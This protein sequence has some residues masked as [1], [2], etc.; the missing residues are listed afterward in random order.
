[1][2]LLLHICCAPCSV[3][4]AQDLL[5]K[6]DI[7]LEGFF[8]NPNI[9]PEEELMKRKSA[10]VSMSEDLKLQVSYDDSCLTDYWRNYLTEEKLARCNVCYSLRL[11][12]AAQFARENGFDAFT[13][14]LLISP[15]QDH[16]LIRELGEQAASK[17]HLQFHYQD[18]RPLYRRGREIARGKNWYMQKFCGCFY[19]YTESTH[20]KKPIYFI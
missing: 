9:H 14:S 7:K 4:I 20:P 5:E 8:Y 18:F 1:M 19:S 2:K 3:A 12:R 16:D 13:T 17:Y 15:W 6:P 11:D 10:V